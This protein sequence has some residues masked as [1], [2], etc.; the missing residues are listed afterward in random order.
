MSLGAVLRVNN[1]QNIV[2][3]KARK[4]TETKI[5]FYSQAEKKSCIPT[6]TIKIGSWAASRG[7]G[8]GCRHKVLVLLVGGGGLCLQTDETFINPVYDLTNGGAHGETKTLSTELELEL[9]SEIS[10]SPRPFYNRII[11]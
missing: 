9:E 4:A 10:G 6:V 5:I 3:V 8:C 7:E 11:E 1:V 2:N